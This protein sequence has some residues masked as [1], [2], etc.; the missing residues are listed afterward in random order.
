M[1]LISNL[2]S[3]SGVSLRESGTSE[4]VTSPSLIFRTNQRVDNKLV[5]LGVYDIF[6]QY[7]GKNAN[8]CTDLN[9]NVYR[10]EYAR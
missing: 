5:V 4:V 7:L 1:G 6:D 10:Y 9:V 2:V 8:W 3:L